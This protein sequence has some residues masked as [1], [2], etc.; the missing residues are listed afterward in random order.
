MRRK[1][2]TE[3][4]RMQRMNKRANIRLTK[5]QVIDSRNMKTFADTTVTLLTSG[6]DACLNGLL[7]WL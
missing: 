4:Q 6:D 2:K 7:V 3:S 1:N 5:P